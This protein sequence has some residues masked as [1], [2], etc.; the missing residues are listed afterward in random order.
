[1]TVRSWTIAFREQIARAN[2]SLQIRQVR[3]PLRAFLCRAPELGICQ[4][5]V[6]KKFA[7]LIPL[8]QV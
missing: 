8:G 1:M 7:G 2:E 6:L 4:H 3:I 5:A